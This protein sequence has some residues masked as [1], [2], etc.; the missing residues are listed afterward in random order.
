M[1]DILDVCSS[2][3]VEMNLYYMLIDQEFWGMSQL[4][5][6]QS[7]RCSKPFDF[8]QTFSQTFSRTFL[9]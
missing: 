9:F 1:P 3:A 6:P 4:L 5:W 7:V 2:K 8:S